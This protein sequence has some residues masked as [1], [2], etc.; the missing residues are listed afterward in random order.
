MVDL[1][2]FLIELKRTTCKF[3]ID[4]IGYLT[5]SGEQ[6]I[7]LSKVSFYCILKHL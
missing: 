6:R 2:N 5:R 3:K 4:K 7:K 1:F